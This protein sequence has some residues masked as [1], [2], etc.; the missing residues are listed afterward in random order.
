MQK[1]GQKLF[2]YY[3]G[4]KKIV[5]MKIGKVY[6]FNLIFAAIKSIY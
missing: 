4:N 5:S 3:L 2:I 1:F 6:Y